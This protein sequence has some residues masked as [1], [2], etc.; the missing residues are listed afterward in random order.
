MLQNEA[1]LL[2]AP[3]LQDIETLYQWE[4]DA[5]VWYLSQTLV[6][7]SHF[8]L[9]QFILQGN[10]DIFAEK[11]FRFMIEEKETGN[12]LGAIDLF[13]FDAYNERAGIGILVD[14][15]YRR[16]GF[17]GMALDLI[18]EYCFSKLKVHQL[19]C[20]IL[21]S[22]TESLKLFRNKNFVIVGVKKDWI[23]NDNQFHDEMLLQYIRKS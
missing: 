13:D 18:I 12:L 7:F 5:K 1:I 16:Q 4:N 20:N 22:N 2:R 9:E 6:P 8:D 21:N 15:K 10:H 11:Q 3:E 19:Y 23:F 14:S 17:A